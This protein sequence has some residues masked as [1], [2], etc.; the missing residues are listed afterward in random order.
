MEKATKVDIFGISNIF[1]V[2]LNV[3]GMVVNTISNKKV[4]D[5]LKDIKRSIA[6]LSQQIEIAKKSNI[7]TGAG[8]ESGGDV[9][10]EPIPNEQV[11][12]EL[13]R[14]YPQD[15]RRLELLKNFNR[16]RLERYMRN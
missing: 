5:D 10:L 12:Q 2:V 1:G 8:Q 6:D 13:T 7:A 3:F 15:A 14:R 9:T 16:D 11:S 4:K